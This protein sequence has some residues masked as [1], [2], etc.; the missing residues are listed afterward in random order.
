MYAGH[1]YYYR[2][3]QHHKAYMKATHFLVPYISNKTN[4]FDLEEKKKTKTILMMNSDIKIVQM[5]VLELI[6]ASDPQQM[7]NH[8]FWIHSLLD[9]KPSLSD[10]HLLPK[11]QMN[12]LMVFHTENDNENSSMMMMWMRLTC[13]D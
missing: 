9:D 7:M 5:N 4:H 11:I 13:D 2:V 6:V 1:Q 10:V 3:E 8:H 12:K